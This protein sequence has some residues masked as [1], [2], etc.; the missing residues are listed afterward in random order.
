MVKGGGRLQK[1]PA[2]GQLSIDWLHADAKIPAVTPIFLANYFFVI[3]RGVG[4]VG[5]GHN[6]GFDFRGIY[7]GSTLIHP[8]HPPTNP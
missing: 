6:Y 2:K 8:P 3:S 4:G 7:R 5:D 1:T